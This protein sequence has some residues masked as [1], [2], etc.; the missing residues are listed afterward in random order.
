MSSSGPSR[1]RGRG[2]KRDR[3]RSDSAGPS[4]RPDKRSK[5]TSENRKRREEFFNQ[6]V[7]RPNDFDKRGKVSVGVDKIIEL[8]ANYFVVNKTKNFNVTCYRLDFEPEVELRKVRSGLIFQQKSKLGVF[9]YDGESQIYLLQSLPEDPMTLR[10]TS[11]EKE[12][13]KLKFRKT[14]EIVYTDAT[15]LQVLNLV[16]RNTMRGLKL[17][18]VGRNYYDPA[19][20]VSFMNYLLYMPLKKS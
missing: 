3:S 7:T 5:K 6:A 15:F 14:R 1:D 2:E 10:S 8:V 13:Y 17:Q 18:L 16:M 12:V 9:L 4:R 20:K 11:R 19:A